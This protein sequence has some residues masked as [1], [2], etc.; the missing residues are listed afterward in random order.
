MS[1]RGLSLQSRPSRRR[2]WRPDWL[3]AIAAELSFE[4]ATVTGA[5]YSSVPDFRNAAN[6]AVQGTDARRPVNG[7]ASNGMAQATFSDDFLDYPLVAATNGAA[8]WGVAFWLNS[9]ADATIRRIISIRRPGAGGGASADKLEI[10]YATT[11]GMMLDAYASD[12]QAYRCRSNTV[13]TGD[14]FWTIE[15]DG[16]QSTDDTKALITLDTTPLTC[17]FEAAAGAQASIPAAL[18]QP[19]GSMYIG[20]LDTVPSLPFNGVLGPRIWFL[21]RQLTALERTKL[22][23]FTRRL[24]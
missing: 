11:R 14:R 24:P 5:G 23:N 9:T 7:T 3:S 20:A 21:N 6:P 19:T 17:T 15:Y 18:P 16:G 2:T 4:G 22:M 12:G 8:K 13:A 1:G 10:C